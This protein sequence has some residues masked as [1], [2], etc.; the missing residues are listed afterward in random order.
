MNR[1]LI[2][3]TA[4]A[5]SQVAMAQQAR[6]TVRKPQPQERSAAAGGTTLAR[7]DGLFDR[8]DANRDGF[9]SAAELGRDS[10]ERASWIA[11][12]RNNDGRISRDEFRGI[13][14]EPRRK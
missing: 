2:A 12:D 14:T 7:D 1:I 6:E 9:L 8:L 11:A 10:A 13:A 4:L 3:A 5:L